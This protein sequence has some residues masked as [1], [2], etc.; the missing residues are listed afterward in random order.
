MLITNYN[1]NGITKAWQFTLILK[2]VLNVRIVNG[3]HSF[4]TDIDIQFCRKES[5]CEG[6]KQT[7]EENQ[8]S[9]AEYQAFESSSRALV[10]ILKI[11]YDRHT[12]VCFLIYHY[13]LQGAELGR[14]E[15]IRQSALAE[16][17]TDTRTDPTPK[18]MPPSNA[19]V[20]ET[21]LNSKLSY[22]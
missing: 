22:R 5:H 4:E 13:S 14:P 6:H 17:P 10:K 1:P 16:G 12:S 3:N 2:I 15:K 19:L 8:F 9:M 18:L 11:G 7:A 20:T 21:V